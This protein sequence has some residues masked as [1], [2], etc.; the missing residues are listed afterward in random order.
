MSTAHSLPK[1]TNS[2]ERAGILSIS[3]NQDETCIAIGSLHGIRIFNLKQGRVLLSE[4]CGAIRFDAFPLIPF[5]IWIRIVE[6][7][8]CTSLLTY[9][10]AGKE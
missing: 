8:F 10:G 9:V 6:M 5:M 7:L 3:V 1:R 2:L 4:D